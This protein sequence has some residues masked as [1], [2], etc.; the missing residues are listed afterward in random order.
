[1]TN[2]GAEPVRL[3]ADGRLLRFDIKLPPKTEP[4]AETKK[5]LVKHPKEPAPVVC[6]LPL[7]MRPAGV[8]DDRAVILRPGARYEEV[9]SPAL[10]CFGNVESAALVAGAEVTA[11]LGF[12]PPTPPKG[13]I[14]KLLPPFIAEPTSVSPT[15]V[16]RKEL[17]SSP[18]VLPAE[19]ANETPANQTT[20]LDAGEPNIEMF[21]PREGRHPQ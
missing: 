1:M 8:S 3:A 20:K 15:I 6:E 4:E 2:E 5:L 16:A 17:V 7:S 9:V 21:V 14:P 18:F 12:V 11:R 10:Y 19:A 13:K